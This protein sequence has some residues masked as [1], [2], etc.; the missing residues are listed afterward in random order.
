LA[1]A[2]LLAGKLRF[3]LGESPADQEALER[4][5][6]YAQETGNHHVQAQASRWLVSTFMLLTIPADAAIA[7]AVQLLQTANSEPWA[8]AEILA[9]LSLVYA[10]AGHFTEA[11]QAIT[12]AQSVHGHSGARLTSALDTGLAGM[13][14]LISGDPAAA[15][16]HL[17][18]GCEALRAMDEHGYLSTSA[19]WLAEA[20]YAQGRLDE[21][22]QM[23][24]EARATAPPVDIDAQAR[25]RV[26]QAKLLARRGVFPAARRLADEAEALVSPTSWAALQAEV[27][28]AK[29]EINRLAGARD[30]AEAS[31][32]AALR[33]YQD[34]HA[35]PLA[36]QAKAALGGLA[37][38]PS[39]EQA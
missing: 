6:A 15:E 8:E 35:T 33:I 28:M 13:T 9:P 16:H 10:Y 11:R 1:E 39:R 24:E 37:A 21:A 29:A 27:L 26:T 32:R 19:G 18:Q 2:W 22:Q 25:W 23:T 36:D 4:A 14:E 5:M 38:R 12:R 3:W 20:L 30:H 34:R 17:K 7:R 31:L